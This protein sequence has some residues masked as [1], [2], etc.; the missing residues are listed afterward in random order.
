[1][2]ANAKQNLKSLPDGGA[3]GQEMIKDAMEI[4]RQAISALDATKRSI[5]SSHRASELLHNIANQPPLSP[6]KTR[7]GRAM[8][9][10]P[11]SPIKRPSK[12]KA[13]VSLETSPSSEAY[14]VDKTDDQTV[15]NLFPRAEDGPTRLAIRRGQVE[16]VWAPANLYIPDDGASKPFFEALHKVDKYASDKKNGKKWRNQ[17]LP[18]QL[19]CA[20]CFSVHKKYKECRIARAHKPLC[21]GKQRCF[22]CNENARFCFFPVLVDSDFVLV[23]GAK[24]MLPSKDD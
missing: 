10:A 17:A 23:W 16:L 3:K 8:Q 6:R 11:A 1:M 15:N 7:A 24:S 13:K 9:Q 19:A 5:I 2:E 4:A 12:K 20:H 21:L 14:L 22:H 18:D